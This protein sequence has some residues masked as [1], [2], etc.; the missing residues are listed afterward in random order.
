MV[1][2][3]TSPRS[4]KSCAATVSHQR[5]HSRLTTGHPML[6]SLSVLRE[7]THLLSP[8][9]PTAGPVRRGIRRGRV[10]ASRASAPSASS[11]GP[12]YGARNKRAPRCNLERR[13][14]GASEVASRRTIEPFRPS[15]ARGFHPPTL[16]GQL[17]WR[18]LGYGTTA[19]LLLLDSPALEAAATSGRYKRP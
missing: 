4:A 12:R 16:L 1:A 18:P 9:P 2:R 19:A 5:Q 6:H 14:R 10:P 17:S 7:E 13:H 15:H 11:S 8:S 3:P